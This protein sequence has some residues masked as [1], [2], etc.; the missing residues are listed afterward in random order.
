MRTRFEILKRDAR[1]SYLEAIA[2]NGADKSALR[3]RLEADL[4][5]LEEE[6][7]FIETSNIG[8]EFMEDDDIARI[9]Q[10]GKRRWHNAAGELTDL[11]SEEEIYNLTIRRGTL[12]T[13]ER[14]IINNHMAVTIKMLEQLPFPKNLESVP[15]IAG[16]HHEKMDGTGYPKG[17]TGDQMSLPARAMAIADIYEALTAADRPYKKANPL[18]ETLR[19]MENMK[20]H[21]HVDP[22]LFD[23]FL[24][25]GVYLKSAEMFLSPEQIDQVDIEQ[26]LGPIPPPQPPLNKVT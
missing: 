26:Y 16:G 1:I 18:S 2:E 10:I 20:Q 17:L 24:T 13:E 21:H 12:T 9:E 8:G 15:E 5:E 7:A 25:S 4:T 22:E 11:L 23:L 6:C 14:D 19:I 3:A